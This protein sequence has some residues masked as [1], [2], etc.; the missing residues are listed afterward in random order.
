[1]LP[2]KEGKAVRSSHRLR[3]ASPFFNALLPLAGMLLALL[4]GAVMLL[5]LKVNPLTAYGEMVAGALGSVSGITQTLVKA[6][7]LLLVGLGICIAFRASV[8][9]IGGE[10]QI[11]VGAIA[12]TWFALTFRTW[13]GWLLVPS[14]LL[15]GFA[16]GALWGFIPGILKAR[17]RVN[18]ILTTVMMNAIALQLMNLL[19]RSV[20]MDPAGITSGTYLAQS[21]RL[22]EQAWLTRLIP[23]TLLNT[24][25]LIAV[26]LAVVVY[27]FLWRTTIGYRIRAVGL[28]PDAARFSG[29]N[30]PFNQALSLTLAGGFAGIAGAIEVMGVQH[31]LLEGITS[32]Y[33]FSGIVAALFGGLHPIGTIPAAILFGGLLVGGDKMQRAVQ[34]PNSLIDAILGLVV[35]FVVGSSL[36]SQRWAARR[37]MDAIKH[38]EEQA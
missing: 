24:G 20:L 37:Q 5:I 34:V 16:S 4:I 30:V 11:I 38:Q 12:A 19:I 28:N 32:G 2:V 6:T 31:R 13:P 35:L 29:I 18:E 7:P 26:G 1:M 15:V 23:Q 21:E 17:L 14:T 3:W 22:P 25:T 33:G 10:G 27:I 9:N 36:W 8:I